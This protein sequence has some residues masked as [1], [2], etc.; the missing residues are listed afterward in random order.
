MNFSTALT[1]SSLTQAWADL[2]GTVT[3]K[4]MAPATSGA[5]TVPLGS[6]TIPASAV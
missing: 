5:I 2:P 4:L 1:P 3:L 6:I